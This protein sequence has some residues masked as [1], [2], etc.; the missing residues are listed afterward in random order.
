L[1]RRGARP[2]TAAW[3]SP[4]PEGIG[5]ICLSGL[6]HRFGHLENYFLHRPASGSVA[7]SAK[8]PVT[9]RSGVTS[10]TSLSWR[11]GAHG[12]PYLH[13]VGRYDVGCAVRTT[14]TKIFSTFIIVSQWSCLG[15]AGRRRVP[16]RP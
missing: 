5:L 3:G 16:G 2:A 4:A 11:S 1:G 10:L 15:T 13:A 7:Q 14:S 9:P 8:R 12:A 6:G